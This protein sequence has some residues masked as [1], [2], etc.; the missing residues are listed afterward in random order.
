MITQPILR[1]QARVCSSGTIG[2]PNRCPRC[3]DGLQLYHTIRGRAHHFLGCLNYPF[4][5]YTADYDQLLHTRLPTLGERLDR[6]E[7]QV[8]WLLVQF[9]VLLAWQEER[10]QA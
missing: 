8:A 9:E 6:A 7:A 3:G 2:L 4:C 5:T 10:G 1:S